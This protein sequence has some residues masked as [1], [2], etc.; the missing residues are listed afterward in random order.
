MAVIN[1]TGMAQDGGRVRFLALTGRGLLDIDPNG[2]GNAEF[3]AFLNGDSEPDA[4]GGFAD[5]SYTESANNSVL[6]PRDV[7]LGFA[8]G[9]RAGTAATGEWCW[10]GTLNTR[11]EAA[12]IPEPGSVA[13]LSLGLMVG[14]LVMRKRRAS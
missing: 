3:I 11:G 10:Q 12:V 13:L 8:E 5:L 9:C 4:A 6:N 14:G 7:A 2:P 1:K